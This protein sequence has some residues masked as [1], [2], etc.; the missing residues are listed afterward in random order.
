MAKGK[1]NDL[2]PTLAG[3]FCLFVVFLMCLGMLG[4]KSFSL[5]SLLMPSLWL[6]LGLCLRTNRKNWLT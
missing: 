5:W 1:N 2:L 6:L 3:I 4:S